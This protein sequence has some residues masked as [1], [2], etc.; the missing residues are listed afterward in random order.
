MRQQDIVDRPIAFGIS[1]DPPNAPDRDDA[2][3]VEKWGDGQYFVQ[4]TI[5]D[6]T[7]F[8]EKDSEVD[9]RARDRAYTHYVRR[10]GHRHMLPVSIAT[11]DASLHA[12][13]VRPGLTLSAMVSGGKVSDTYIQRTA[14]RSRAQLTYEDVA[15]ILADSSHP[16]REQLVQGLECASILAG[17]RNARGS[18]VGY[19]RHNS[20]IL[21]EDGNV[22]IIPDNQSFVG[23][24]IVQELMILIN[25]IAAQ[26]MRVAGIP[27]L[28]RNQLQQQ[29]NIGAQCVGAGLKALLESES[30]ANPLVITD[31][32]VNEFQKARYDPTGM[33]H[34]SLATEVYTHISAPIRRYADFVNHRILIALLEGSE[35]PYS[36]DELAVLAENLAAKERKY[37]DKSQDS[38]KARITTIAQDLLSRALC[39]AASGEEFDELVRIAAE[40][41]K[42]GKGLLMAFEAR[43]GSGD[44]TE[45][46]LFHVLITGRVNT[47]PE[48]QA[49]R[50]YAY[51]C[52]LEMHHWTQGLIEMSVQRLQWKKPAL[53]ISDQGG[54]GNGPWTVAAEMTV[55][56]VE[57]VSQPHAFS[58]EKFAKRAAHLDLMAQ[59]AGIPDISE[60][61]IRQALS[62][63]PIVRTR[64]H[65]AKLT[66][67]CQNI[68]GWSDP[69]Y[70]DKEIGKGVHR[71]YSSTVRV[72][73]PEEVLLA[74]PEFAT[75]REDARD[76]VAEAFLEKYHTV[77]N[78][79]AST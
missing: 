33:G 18:L 15:P 35:L 54:T 34:A 62:I 3:W 58:T 53:A 13:V 75:Y 21:T 17:M 56:G 79:P 6:P 32:W 49:L 12:G 1:I 38:R 28:Y 73:T 72:V 50:T 2:F 52:L 30:I 19:N 68:E 64:S 5:A 61:V 57:F 40:K 36:Y 14:F 46:N 42:G 37:F 11:Q 70:D 29:K 20:T 65:A 7:Y 25:E 16:F 55:D 4:V 77:C 76:R 41:G 24:L 9:S 10:G 8:V 44:I 74:G 63:I 78:Q 27:C 22:R 31:Q 60:D 43:K 71:A 69:E 26:Q 47:S 48:W 51:G 23:H 39:S 45:N 66:V 67:I 59:I